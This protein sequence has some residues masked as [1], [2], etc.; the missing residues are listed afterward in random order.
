MNEHRFQSFYV[1]TLTFLIN[2]RITVLDQLV[3]SNHFEEDYIAVLKFRLLFDKFY[4][5]ILRCRSYF[6]LVLFFHFYYSQI[7]DLG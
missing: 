5:L 1:L 2:I 4:L 6:Y 7:N 3:H